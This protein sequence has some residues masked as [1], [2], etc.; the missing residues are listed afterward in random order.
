WSIAEPPA[1]PT[2][3]AHAQ[4]RPLDSGSAFLC[5]MFV[6]VV[7][8][9]VALPAEATAPG[10]NA[11]IVFQ[12]VRHY[13]WVVNS[14]GTGERQLTKFKG[15]E[16]ANPDWSPGGSLIAFDR[17]SSHCEIWTVKADGT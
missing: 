1:A 10:R 6:A 16:D 9:L 4:A 11:A 2:K 13:L 5:V 3:D 7:S 14:D 8:A 15:A 12:H 17:C